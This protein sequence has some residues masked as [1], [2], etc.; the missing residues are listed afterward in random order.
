MFGPRRGREYQQCVRNLSNM[1]ATLFSF[2]IVRTGGGAAAKFGDKQSF[3]GKG[4]RDDALRSLLRR[5][6]PSQLIDQDAQEGTGRSLDQFL[7]S[8][9]Q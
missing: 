6:Q 2:E 7:P 9:R 8:P 4:N 5:L 3:V 1:R